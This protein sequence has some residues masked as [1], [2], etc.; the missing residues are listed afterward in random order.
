LRADDWP[1]GLRAV[2][3]LVSTACLRDSRNSVRNSTESGLSS[4]TRM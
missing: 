3:M 4:T 1:E 2:E